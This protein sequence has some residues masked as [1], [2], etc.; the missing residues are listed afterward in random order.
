MCGVVGMAGTLAR[1]EPAALQQLVGAMADTLAH[2]GPNAHG[3]WLSPAAP[4]AFGHR[5][6]SILDPSPAADQ[7]MT[8]DGPAGPAAL[9][10]NG[11][12][13]NFAQLREALGPTGRW[14]TSGDTEVLLRACRE[15]GPE[16]AAR[17]ARGM[18]AFA[19]YDPAA[20]ELWLGRDRFGEKP[21]YYAVWDGSIVFAS[22]LKAIR[23]VPGFPTELDLTAVDE[24]MR[25]SVIGGDRTVYRAARKVQPGSLVR[26]PVS[27]RIAADALSRV[28]HWDTIAEAEKA[29]ASPFAGDLNEAADALDDA[30]FDATRLAAVSDVPIGALLSGGVDSTAVVAQLAGQCREPV[31]TFTVGFTHGPVDETTAARRIAEHLGTHHHEVMVGPGEARAVIPELP[32]V[33]DEPFADSSQIPTLLVTR[34]AADHV[35]VALVGDGGDELL[36]GYPRYRRAERI[37]TAVRRVRPEVR[38]RAAGLLQWPQPETIDRLGHRVGVGPVRRFS[39]S[40]SERVGKLARLVDATSVDEVYRMFVTAY[41]ECSALST[42]A[43]QEV[44]PLPPAPTPVERMMLWDLVAYLPDDLLTK[45]DRAAMANSLETRVPFLDPAVFRLA[46]RLPARFKTDRT[47]GKIVLKRMLARRV[48]RVLW[49]RPKVGF[50]IPLGAWLRGPL[51]PWVDEML[52]PEVFAAHGLLNEELIRR[53]WREHLDGRRDWGSRLWNAVSFQAWYRHWMV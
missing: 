15:W 5:R 39:G 14:R 45:V 42:A 47:D 6:L 8:V 24:F 30:L 36:G 28:V 27:D 51:R 17:R 48:P 3:T 11:E 53:H 9:A 26:V 1:M 13:Y 40:W 35:K 43:L 10:F 12:I 32:V 21:L 23:A 33:Y 7:P 44:R 25:K 37:W 22:E 18:F 46:Q 29:A 52:A 50:G 38:S 41:W 19:Y 20:G 16:V 31:R 34:F 49:D 4:V 2:R